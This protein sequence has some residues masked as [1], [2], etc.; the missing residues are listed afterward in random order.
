MSREVKQPCA[1]FVIRVQERFH[2]FAGVTMLTK[3]LGDHVCSWLA[4]LLLRECGLWLHEYVDAQSALSSTSSPPLR[5]KST[6]P[7]PVYELDQI[8]GCC[9]VE[10][11]MIKLLI[12]PQKKTTQVE[13]TLD[14]TDHYLSDYLTK[15]RTARWSGIGHGTAKTKVAIT[16]LNISRLAANNFGQDNAGPSPPA[17]PPPS[18]TTR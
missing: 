16:L 18:V 17:C 5:M 2:F 7:L 1:R 9:V 6:P 8:Q 10:C 15:A 4:M 13:G 11:V 3:I 12:F 14:I